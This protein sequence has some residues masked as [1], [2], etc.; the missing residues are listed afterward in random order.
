VVIGIFGTKV[1]FSWG[2]AEDA[3]AVTRPF[4]DLTII[5]IFNSFP[6]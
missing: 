2:W 5:I 3:F 4:E 6:P 1:R